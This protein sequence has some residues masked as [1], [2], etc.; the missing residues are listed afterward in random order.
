MI[1][2]ARQKAINIHRAPL[3]YYIAIDIDMDTSIDA[4]IDI[5]IDI[6]KSIDI[7]TDINCIQVT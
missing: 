2:T 1:N 5:F 4:D 7:D 6:D 3:K